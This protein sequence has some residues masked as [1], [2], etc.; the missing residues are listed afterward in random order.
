[1]LKPGSS[2]AFWGY[3]AYPLKKLDLALKSAAAIIEP[4]SAF[5]SKII[6]LRPLRLH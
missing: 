4:Y 1:M 6:G 5:R 3:D 2:H